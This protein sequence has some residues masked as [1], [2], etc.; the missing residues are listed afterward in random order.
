MTSVHVDDDCVSDQIVRFVCEFDGTKIPD[1]VRHVMR[2]SLIDWVA[3]AVAGRN[4]PVAQIL[5]KIG[6]GGGQARGISG[7]VWPCMLPARMAAKI[8]GT[9]SHALDY[10]DTHFDSMGH[11]SVVVIPAALSLADKLSAPAPGIF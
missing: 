7:W 9:L 8:N 10:D 1:N 11:T 5:Q 3:V 2:L 6:E 4:E